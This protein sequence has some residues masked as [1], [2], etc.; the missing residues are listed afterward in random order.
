MERRRQPAARNRSRSLGKK[1]AA[2]NSAII[3]ASLPNI[4]KLITYGEITVGV[5]RPVGCVATATDEDQC[6]AMLVRRRGE[7]FAQLLTRLDQAIEKALTEDIYTDEINPPVS[8]S[9]NSQVSTSFLR[10]RL[11]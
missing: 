9:Y 4:A 2:K 3:P 5:L 1:A 7:S 10:G 8:T 11:R 6:L